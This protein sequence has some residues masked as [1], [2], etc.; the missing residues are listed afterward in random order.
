MC[1]ADI[2]YAADQ[3][4]G[5]VFVNCL[6]HES[7]GSMLYNFNNAGFQESNKMQLDTTFKTGL[8]ISI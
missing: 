2:V 1:Y 6:K 5:T 3:K 8:T 4:S 7:I